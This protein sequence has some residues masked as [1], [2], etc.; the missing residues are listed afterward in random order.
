MESKFIIS[1]GCNCDYAMQMDNAKECLRKTFPGI[2][3]TDTIIS[4]AYG[5]EGEVPDY[6]NMLA[7]GNTDLSFDGLREKLKATERLLGDTTE[8]RQQGIVM[9][10]LD[11]L[12]YREVRHHEKDW[13]K[14]YIKRLLTLLKCMVL[15]IMIGWGIEGHPY[16]PD[17]KEDTELLGKAVEYYQGRKY[18]ECVL[19]FEKLQK[20]YKLNARFKAYLGM[21]YYKDM[22]YEHAVENLKAALPELT[23]YSPKEQAV[24]NYSCAESLFFLE[25]Y[26]EAITYYDKALPL[27]ENPDTSFVNYDKSD[28]IY[29]TAFSYYMLNDYPKAYQLFKQSLAIYEAKPASPDDALHNAR[30]AQVTN[31][32]RWLK[33]RVEE[34]K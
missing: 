15:V 10:D 16:S 32:L 22:Q 8:F 4:P 14:P 27:T 1:I 17:K 5:V 13:D 25:R 6:A 31:M 9:M 7:E 12:Q 33:E 2:T 20:H 29:H 11:I 34:K 24:Y 21:S 28:V 26:R 18:H 19:A 30:I 23:A 3:F